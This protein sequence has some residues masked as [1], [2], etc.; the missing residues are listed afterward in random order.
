MQP[1]G[2]IRPGKV[3]ASEAGEIVSTKHAGS[4]TNLQAPTTENSVASTSKGKSRLVAQG[5]KLVE[6]DPA[7]QSQIKAADVAELAGI[8]AGGTTSEGSD[9]EALVGRL[10]EIVA[11]REEGADVEMEV[12]ERSVNAEML[13][14]NRLAIE[15]VERTTTIE[16][17]KSA[18]SSRR[19]SHRPSVEPTV[20]TNTISRTLKTPANIPSTTAPTSRKILRPRISHTEANLSPI[21]SQDPAPRSSDDHEVEQ[22]HSNSQD[23]E[24]LVRREQERVSESSALSDVEVSSEEEDELDASYRASREDPIDEDSSSN[25]PAGRAAKAAAVEKIKGNRRSST[26]APPPAKRQKRGSTAKNVDVDEDE[27]EEMVEE[28]IPQ[29]LEILPPHPKVITT[30]KK[31][32]PVRAAVSARW[33]RGGRASTS[34]NEDEQ[35][36]DEEIEEEDQLLSALPEFVLHFSSL[37][38]LMLTSSH[39]RSIDDSSKA[40]RSRAVATKGN[41]K[42]RSRES[43]ETDE[44]FWNEPGTTVTAPSK[45]K[46]QPRASVAAA[47]KLAAKPA[48]KSTR[49]GRKS[50]ENEGTAK[51]LVGGMKKKGESAVVVEAP[52]SKR[53]KA[54]NAIIRSVFLF[55]SRN[56]LR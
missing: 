38:Q 48:A 41:S 35:E 49:G 44:A 46:R 20:V 40:K 23:R 47:K 27:D 17:H 50:V 36:M 13:P 39:H 55:R 51:K 43:D 30:Y 31:S 24:E 6:G 8:R 21:A 5:S 53:G 26:T 25:R 22:S 32:S 4:S 18:N 11:D 9:A 37:S 56:Y 3:K 29:T 16:I 19:T 2:N 7:N 54:K 33:S 34:R 42:K 52:K 1:K 15:A 45:A 10:E 28:S 12:V 14:G